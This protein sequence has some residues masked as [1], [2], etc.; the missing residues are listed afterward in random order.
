MNS[1]AWFVTRAGL[2]AGLWA[3]ASLELPAQLPAPSASRTFVSMTKNEQ[4]GEMPPGTPAPSDTRAIPPDT[5][6][7][8]GRT[9]VLTAANVLIRI[10]DRTG[11]QIAT[12]DLSSWW[13]ALLNAD[14][15]SG[16]PAPTSA[17]DPVVVYDVAAHRWIFVCSSDA[18][19]PMSR[20]LIAVSKGEDP[21]SGNIATPTGS[22]A[23]FWFGFVISASDSR[24]GYGSGTWLDQ[25]TV[26]FNRDII[27]IATTTFSLFPGLPLGT[28]LVA[29]NKSAAY[30]GALSFNA[31]R[32]GAAR[33]VP[34][35]T[36]DNSE[37]LHCVD[38]EGNLFGTDYPH[39]TL[40]LLPGPDGQ[41]RYRD[42]LPG[43]G[44]GALGNPAYFGGGTTSGVGPQAFDT[45]FIDLGN[46]RANS[47]VCRDGRLLVAQRVLVNDGGGSSQIQWVDIQTSTW[48]ANQFGRFGSPGVFLSYPSVALNGAGDALIGFSVMSRSMFP[49]AGFAFRAATDPSGTF[50]PV[51]I[52]RAGSVPYRQLDT[53][54]ILNRNRW[55]DYSATCV[56]PL[57][58]RTM[59]T[60]QESTP[61]SGA[62]NRYQVSWAA[63]VPPELGRPII[64]SGGLATAQVGGTVQHQ[65]TALNLP[66]VGTVTFGVTQVDGT[67]A[68][69]WVVVDATTGQ[70]TFAFPP[71]S[72]TFVFDQSVTTAGGEAHQSLVVTVLTS[73]L[74]NALDVTHSVPVTSR[75][76]A[77][78]FRE[79]TETYDHQDAAQSGAIHDGQSSSMFATVH[80]PNRGSFRWKCDS[81]LYDRLTFSI[82][83]NA[84]T[85]A[86]ISGNR[87]GAWELVTFE[88]PE[89]MHRLEWRYSKDGAVSAGQDCGWVDQLLLEDLTPPYY[90]QF[91]PPIIVWGLE[92]PG[93]FNPPP[94]GDTSRF[95]W[96]G[97]LPAGLIFDPTSGQIAGQPS[98]V[99][100]FPGVLRALNA[101]GFID[102]PLAIQVDG[103]P[104]GQA[105][106]LPNAQVTTSTPKGWAADASEPHLKNGDASLRSQVIN[107]GE[108]SWLEVKVNGPASLSF[109]WKL[110]GG[111]V[112]L[113]VDGSK[114]AA[115]TDDTEWARQWL[116]LPAGQHALR[117][118]YALDRVLDSGE[119]E[120]TLPS[121]QAAWV[122]DLV[123]VAPAAPQFQLPPMVKVNLNAPV[124]FTPQANNGVMG[125]QLNGNLPAGLAFDSTTGR[126][127]GSPQNAGN[128]PLTC[129]ASNF[130]GATQ[131]MF[132]LQVD[133]SGLGPALGQST[134]LPNTEPKAPW[135]AQSLVTQGAPT[136]L[137]S[138]A[139]PDLGQSWVEVP[140]TGPALL[141][142]WWR[143]SSETNQDFLRLL[144]DGVERGNLSGE[145]PWQMI[146]LQLSAGEH[147]LHWVYAKDAAGKAG[148]DAG[149]LG[150]L[151]LR[152]L[153]IPTIASAPAAGGRQ[154]IP[155]SAFVKVEN[156]PLLVEVTGNLPDGLKF[157]AISRRFEGTPTKSGSYIV[158]VS[159]TNEAGAAAQDLQIVIDGLPIEIGVDTS[160][161]SWTTA[162]NLPWFV[163]NTTMHDG[164][165]AA[166]SGAQTGEPPLSQSW[167]QA[168]ISSG[169]DLTFWWRIDAGDV[170]VLQLEVDGIVAATLNGESDWRQQTVTLP[171]GDHAVRWT[172]ERNASGNR[173]SDAAWLD[174]V[175]FTPGPALP[176]IGSQYS[177]SGVIG[178]ALS[179]SPKSTGGLVRSFSWQ[180]DWPVGLTL[181]AQSGT[182]SGQPQEQG[183]F[184][185]SLTAENSAGSS[186]ALVSFA[187]ISSFDAWTKA[188]GVNGGAA[189]DP[190]G[191][192]LPNLLEY[193]LG[194]SP[195]D[196]TP[197]AAARLPVATVNH[198]TQR[199]EFTFPE[200]PVR[201][202]TDIIFETTE[203]LDKTLW[204]PVA[205]R[206]PGGTWIPVAEGWAVVAPSVGNDR[207]RILPP[208]ESPRVFGRWH[209]VITE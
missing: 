113:S 151:T 69:A 40:Q 110:E 67:P 138:G 153:E 1:F 120:G 27:A 26:G 42:D 145:A 65:I 206:Y 32:L 125:W 62:A 51:T 152:H 61:V 17:F 116:S 133:G 117:W 191:D 128:F 131:V 58:D 77:E 13:N 98:V 30:A 114:Q 81:E 181:D 21:G 78:W 86:H 41:I 14:G 24:R 6:G 123:V 74:A 143:V 159:A 166:Q 94:P 165:D 163:Q 161:I 7:A 142:F 111:S 23:N 33:L 12:Y 75:G 73:A 45:T 71:V 57:D 164:V 148:Q 186:T 147:L 197:N 149:W 46:G 139:T 127:S 39:S 179:F 108:N 53:S 48:T 56:D 162:T 99:G 9:R 160:G 15:L 89:G 84:S 157:N 144:V 202:G 80:G 140:V 204:T 47:A 178:Q 188:V 115:L 85:L 150:G 36:L 124:D 8:V 177:I 201:A 107:R 79:T 130:A 54:N 194:S 103:T 29:L 55:G 49:S 109:W 171:A 174:E 119:Q 3:A 60:V 101:A 95:T 92:N 38:V 97:Q 135:F 175:T 176:V 37:L 187:I 189:G 66:A 136:A 112:T 169:G 158:T 93:L 50:R 64:S 10:Q 52:Y 83:G 11:N 208:A 200:P 104:L 76:A 34:A 155:I 205:K 63:V 172:Y 121:M 19:S 96:L 35:Q 88:L 137:Q 198:L 196:F 91:P 168:E 2:A 22:P 31:W 102:V 146:T 156:D 106:G 195:T 190:D 129:I 59:W 192:G 4:P 68:P 154:G 43:L 118:T 87:R 134:F 193:I 20:T 90:D 207:V 105:L 5:T 126:L 199:A 16:R 170:D 122:D 44:I 184:S 173:R 72:G 82:D 28:S 180:G 141:S 70:I 209:M 185:L 182:I 132:Q 183:N 25:P 167:V 203:G 18:N 100:K